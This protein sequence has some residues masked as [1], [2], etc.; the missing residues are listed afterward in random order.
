MASSLPVTVTVGPQNPPKPSAPTSANTADPLLERITFP[1]FPAPPPG[2]TI[3]PFKQFK[4]AGIQIATE[5]PAP[6]YVERDGTGA[7]TV[8]L[9]VKHSLTAAEQH[10]R[11]KRAR[12]TLPNGQTRRLLW[13]EEWEDGEALR[14]TDVSPSLPRFD[15]LK[16]A[17]ADFKHGRP[18]PLP[19]TDT[20]KLWDHFRLS[21]GMITHLNPPNAN[22][23]RQRQQVEADD[24][25]ED[26]DS[27]PKDQKVVI[28]DDEEARVIERERRD[29]ERIQRQS[30]VLDEIQQ[31][32]KDNFYEIRQMRT[33]AFF[34][35]T[36]KNMKIFFSSYFREKG[37]IW[38]TLRCRDAP[39]MLDFF[40]RFL[41]RSRVFPEPEYEKGFRKALAIVEQAKKELPHTFTIGQLVP[42]DFSKGCVQLWGDMGMLI[43]DGDGEET[44]EDHAMDT[45]KDTNADD[46]KT[47]LGDVDV[48]VISPEAVA[49]MET[50]AKQDPDS[51]LA[52]N[53]ASGGWGNPAAVPSTTGDAWGASGGWGAADENNGWGSGGASSWTDTPSPNA[54]TA[55]LGPTPLPLTHTTGLVERSTRRIAQVVPPDARRAPKK[56]KRDA[57]AA[58][59]VEEELAARL[60]KV[61]L[62][63]WGEYDVHPRA[64]VTHPQFLRDSR[65]AVA[66]DEAGD[67][68]P[69][70]PRPF[71]PYKDEI[72]VLIDPQIAQHMWLGMG[73]GATWVQLVRQDPTK[74]AE[75]VETKGKKKQKGGAGEPGEPTKFWYMEQLSMILPS[76]H[77]EN[78]P[79]KRPFDYP[80]QL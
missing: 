17:C 39:I 44:K 13:F 64:E 77:T 67:S 78:V 4:P 3:V 9:R 28:V 43:L 2:V 48:E 7:P 16:Q 36:E 50:E 72:T 30:A 80:Q 69:T 70:G 79:H 37:L 33:D 41:L 74:S 32:R 58:E 61:V 56:K 52:E 55:F 20:F 12:V 46:I 14:R 35:D 8:A 57:G 23:A 26:G 66:M 76:F 53:L 54:L 47:I 65:G 29:Q 34:D 10:K 45:T 21:T 11:N 18:F 15:R 59:Q 1:P 42:D 31:T 60:A 62:V 24:D 73:L 38:S 63:P 19:T 27:K 40:L 6:G 25:D 49:D 68:A 51:T 22:K 5:D 75:A 71:N